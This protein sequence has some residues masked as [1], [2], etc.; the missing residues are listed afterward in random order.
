LLSVS[1]RCRR[2]QPH[3]LPAATPSGVTT[4]MRVYERSDS[5]RCEEHALFERLHAGDA[6]ARA[7]LVSRFL[8]L[9]RQLAWSM[10]GGEDL[11]D[12]E[13][14]AAI[15]LMKAIDRFDPVRGFAFSSFAVPTIQGELKRHYRD[16]VWFVRV[17]RPVRDLCVRV[18]RVSSAL[19]GELG[20]SPTVA[21]IA[22]RADCTDERVLEALVALTSRHPVSLDQPRIAADQPHATGYEVAAEDPGYADVDDA[23]LLDGLMADLPARDRLI[24]DLRFRQDQRQSQIA[25]VLGLSQMQVSRLIRRSIEQL[26]LAAAQPPEPRASGSAG[27]M[28]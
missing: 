14:V 25:E 11:D 20:R 19:S 12:L 5:S 7:A 28:R 27:V 13:Q 22:E 18:E 10:R 9:A 1:W 15:G 21:E 16:R 8:P 4:G 2:D 23:E 26:R 3:D 6:T 17:P 24:L